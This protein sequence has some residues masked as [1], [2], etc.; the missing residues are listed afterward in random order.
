MRSDGW[1]GCRGSH[2]DWRLWNRR[3]ERPAKRRTGIAGRACCARR[4]SCGWRGSNSGGASMSR[5]KTTK[6]EA[7]ENTRPIDLAEEGSHKGSSQDLPLD[8]EDSGT[9]PTPEELD[10]A[11]DDD[12]TDPEDLLEDD[13]QEEEA[14]DEEKEPSLAARRARQEWINGKAGSRREDPVKTYLREIGKVPLLTKEGEV[15]LAKAMEIGAYAELSLAV[16]AGKAA[17]KRLQRPRGLTEVEIRQ[18][19][20]LVEKGDAAAELMTSSAFEEKLADELPVTTDREA[21]EHLVSEGTKAKDRLTISNL[22]LV[23]SIAKR[24]MN[25]GLSFLDLIQEGN[26]GLMKAVEKF[27]FTRGYKFSTYATWWIRQAITRAIAD[28]SRTIRV[29][30]HMIETVREL[31]RVKREYIQSHGSAPTLEDLSELTGM[32]IDKIK[33][34]ESVSQYT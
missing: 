7:P 12:L 14:F 10:G 23:V 18:C 4:K 11:E 9:E 27:D 32:S 20:D 6:H 21:L 19:E 33:K 34:V 3:S 29:P 26:M 31:N 30:V 13:E 28:Q 25:R 2:A 24:Y 15:T 1:A 17:A 8:V 22:R 16:L 5:N